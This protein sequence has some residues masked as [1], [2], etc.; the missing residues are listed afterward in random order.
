MIHESLDLSLV[1]RFNLCEFRRV[2]VQILYARLRIA[3][4][5]LVQGDD[6]EQ[7][8]A[9]LALFFQQIPFISV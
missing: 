5:H 7:E 4:V 1:H 9:N 6:E 3:D 2:G 8:C